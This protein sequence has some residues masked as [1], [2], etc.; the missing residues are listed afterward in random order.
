MKKLNQDESQRTFSTG[1][2]FKTVPL[3]SHK[4]RDDVQIKPDKFYLTDPNFN[5]IDQSQALWQITD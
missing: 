4:E 3:I 5:D 2:S 1:G